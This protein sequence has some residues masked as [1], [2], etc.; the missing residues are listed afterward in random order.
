MKTK[1][2]C[3]RN[4]RFEV[5]DIFRLY[6]DEYQGR[7][8]LSKGQLKVM[9]H[10]TNCRTA[11]MGGHVEICDRCGFRQNA[12]NSCR[13]RH[14]P[15]CQTMVKEKWLNDRRAKVRPCGHS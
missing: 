2:T 14:C 11:P 3:S 10:I 9:S 13:D 4:R 6:G 8:R 12:Y 15:K 5:A 7:N 1:K